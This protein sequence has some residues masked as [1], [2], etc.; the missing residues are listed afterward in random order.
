MVTSSHEAMHRI[1]Q[2]DAAAIAHAF[3]VL[4][5]PF[6]KPI[7]VEQV[8]VDLTETAPVERRADTVL[9]ITTVDD[10]FLM[11]VE[12][13]SAPDDSRPDSWS[14]YVTFLR[15]KYHLPVILVV[16]CHDHLTAR[17]A[18]TPM[19][20]G[21]TFWTTI[22]L[23][24]LVLGPHNVPA[25]TDPALVIQDLPLA[26]LSAVT[27]AREA[28][29]GAILEAIVTG[30]RRTGGDET[31]EFYVE[32][33]EQGISHTAAAETWRKYMATDLSFFRSESAQKL[34]AQGRE[35]GVAVGQ[36]KAVLQ[37]L[38]YREVVVTDAAAQRIRDCQDEAKLATWL[39]RALE[40]SSVAELF[41]D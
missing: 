13:Q 4:K 27:H 23:Y 1:F 14:Y 38:R 19:E 17:W 35:E 28:D 34:R 33:I 20:I 6:A 39:R 37:V 29:I 31:T 9:D 5:L 21:H 10:R 32:L 41:D 25:V 15:N 7:A 2:H 12:A 18:S 26:A 3:T 8:S 11:V 22:T 40:V 30:I 36:A 16:I 24:P